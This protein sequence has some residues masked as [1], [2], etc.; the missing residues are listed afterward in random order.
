M[1]VI[2][3]NG[4]PHD[5]GSV[6]TSLNLIST[7]LAKENIECEILQVGNKTIRG[8]RACNKCNEIKRCIF[9]DDILN[10]YLEKIKAAD[11]LIIGSPV[12]YGGIAGTLKC[13]LD[14]VFYT[15]PDMRFKVCAAV[16]SLRRSGGVSTFQQINNYFNLSQ[17]VLT[18]SPYWGVIHGNNGDEVLQDKE[19]VQIMQTIGQNMS[20]LMKVVEQGKTNIKQPQ[21]L[22]KIRT[23]FIR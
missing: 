14:R 15:R 20:W 10:E 16:V 2:A 12:Y 4:S 5:N 19:G 7:E 3:I 23:N 21:P 18:P 17:M 13:F 6:F 22:E 9:N 11:G 1:K 8:C